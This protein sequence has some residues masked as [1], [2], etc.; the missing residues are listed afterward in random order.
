MVLKTITCITIKNKGQMFHPNEVF[1]EHTKIH[2]L[3]TEQRGKTNLANEI[4]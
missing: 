1:A 4:C 2:I 3:I